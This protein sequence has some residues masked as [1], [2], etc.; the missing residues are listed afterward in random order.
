MPVTY[1]A[2]SL[3]RNRAVAAMSSG[4]AARL[5]GMRSMNAA[6]TSGRLVIGATSGVAVSPGDTVVTRMPCSA[7][8]SAPDCPS[9]TTPA[10]AEE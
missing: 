4:L 10:L 7:S 8:S 6:L 5:S 1:A 2:S 9:M 3:A